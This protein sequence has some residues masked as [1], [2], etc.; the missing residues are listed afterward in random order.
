MSLR[1]TY[2]AARAAEK[3]AEPRHLEDCLEFASRAW[4]RPLADKEKLGL[5]AF[6]AKTLAVTLLNGS[7][8]PQLPGLVEKWIG[9]NP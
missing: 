1:K 6:Y 9:H 2:D 4:R 7:V 8:P 5:R 3:A